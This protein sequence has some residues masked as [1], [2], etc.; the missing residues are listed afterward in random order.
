MIQNIMNIGKSGLA[1]TRDSIALTSSNIVNSTTAGYKRLHSEFHTLVSH[2]LDKDSYPNY[3]GDVQT[4]TGVKTST[5]FRIDEQ[6]M[7][8]NTGEYFT[9]A[10]IGE[11]YFRV[12]LPDGTYAYTRSGQFGVDGK[13][14]IVDDFGNLLDIT[15]EEGYSYDNIDFS[16]TSNDKVNIT[17]ISNRDGIDKDGYIRVDG[18][19]I[20]RINIYNTVG[21]DDLRSIRDNLFVPKEGANMVKSKSAYMRQG[22]LELSNVSMVDELTDL[23]TLQRAYQ[24]NSKGVTTADEMWGLVNEM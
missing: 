5:A 6:G 18:N 14:R 19:V 24:L 17:G 13:G 1:S 3:S 7:L 22:Y 9:F 20:G 16:N 4:G 21:D 12:V 8:K 10:I 2:N 23:I 15:F 11:G